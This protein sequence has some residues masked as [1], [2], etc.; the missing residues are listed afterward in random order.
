[1]VALISIPLVGIG[2]LL[3]DRYRGAAAAAV[4]KNLQIAVE[5]VGESASGDLV[6]MEGQLETVANILRDPAFGLPFVKS[7]VSGAPNLGA[8]GIYDNKGVKIDVIRKPGDDSVMPETLAPNLKAEVDKAGRAVGEVVAS[9]SGPRLPLVLPV[10]GSGATWYVLA[11][12]PTAKLADQVFALVGQH[13]DNNHEK[14]ELIDSVFV[15]DRKLRVVAHPDPELVQTMHDMSKE[16]VLHALDLSEVGDT[17]FMRFTEFTGPKGPMFG[18]VYRPASLP[19]LIVAQTPRAQA[20][21]AFDAARTFVIIAI[22]VSIVL[23]II[24]AFLITRRVTAPL[25]ELAAFAS[26][27]GQRKFDKRLAITT[28]DEFEVVGESMSAAAAALQA[29]DEQ[30]KKEAAIRSDLGR[31]LPGQLVDLVIRREHKIELGGERRCVTVLFADVASFTSLTEQHPPDVVVAILNQLFTI[32]TDIVFRHGGTVDK[33]IGDCVMAFWNAPEEDSAHATHALYAAEDMLRW[34]E[35]GNESWRANYGVTIH[36]AI[37]VNTGEVIVGNLG[38]D[39]RMEYTC[40]G[41]PVNVA[42][43]LEGLAR[44]QQI[45]VSR[46][47]KDAAGD[48]F[49]YLPAGTQRIP[50]RVEPLELFEVVV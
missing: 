5:R 9:P 32:L 37:G 11:E 3:I 42:A 30:L 29:G 46:A 38:S 21:G 44:P 31:Y 14:L 20:L 33:F 48:G 49:D 7:A 26:E 6:A 8:V 50:G 2:W 16:P 28:G 19:L 4:E 40:I 35:I 1:M 17:A 45:V 43:R 25:L 39:T 36:L 10:S 24:A 27:L 12:L 41:D 34:L 23:A 47:T 18:T 22:A 15:L 13:F